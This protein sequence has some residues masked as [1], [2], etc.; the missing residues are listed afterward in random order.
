MMATAWPSWPARR[1]ARV[2]A[3]PPHYTGMPGLEPISA[4][5]RLRPAVTPSPSPERPA[6]SRPERRVSRD[7]LER[8]NRRL[9]ERDRVIL[10]SLRHHHFLTT[11]QLQRFHFTGHGSP[12]TAGRLC[13]RVLARLHELRLIEHL[14]RRIGGVR[15]GSASYVWRVGLIGDRLLR[16]HDR[17]QP[18]ARRKEPSLHH[19]QHCLAVADAHLALRELAATTTTELL[20]V[21]TE[22]ACWRTYRDP[23]GVLEILKPDLYVVTARG[24]YEDH[25]FLEIDRATESL[26]TLLKKCG[27]YQ[28]YRHTGEAQQR[29]GVFPWVLW[30]VPTPAHGARLRKAIDQTVQLTSE[31][32]R[33]CTLAEL[34]AVVQDGSA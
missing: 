1:T 7:Q 24:D 17:E 25:W 3:M 28:A 8:L 33:V 16:L 14:E 21:T 13:R 12:R 22:P 15:A 20:Q 34:P 19:L 18:R 4:P 27:Q 11:A 23:A 29:H 32:F 31:L 2:A 9:S 10:R 30:V 5:E 6:A 26:P